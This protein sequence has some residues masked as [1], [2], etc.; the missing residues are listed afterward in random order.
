MSSCNACACYGGEEGGGEGRGG[1]S[2]V[3]GL[4]EA[5]DLDVQRFGPEFASSSP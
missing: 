2:L 4:F 1:G 3:S 5:I